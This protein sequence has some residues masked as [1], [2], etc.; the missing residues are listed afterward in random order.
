VKHS[1]RDLTN[2]LAKANEIRSILKEQAENRPDDVALSLCLQSTDNRIKDVRRSLKIAEREGGASVVNERE[3]SKVESLSEVESYIQLAGYYM[4]KGIEKLDDKINELRG[5]MNILAVLGE[6]EVT[7]EERL[8]VFEDTVLLGY[9]KAFY[10]G[11][12]R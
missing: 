7:P 11:T 10:D 4:A 5:K 2:R 6:T 3:V 1:V 9:W 8:S 12:D